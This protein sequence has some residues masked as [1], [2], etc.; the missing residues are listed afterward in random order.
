MPISVSPN[1][2]NQAPASRSYNNDQVER[3]KRRIAEQEAK[4]TSLEIKIKELG[5]QTEQMCLEI[6]S[7]G[8]QTAALGG[9]RFD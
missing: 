8:L 6:S 2:P 7:F 3:L 9:K 5:K 1:L 4:V